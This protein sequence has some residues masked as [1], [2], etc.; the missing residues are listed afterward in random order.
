MK[1]FFSHPFILS[2]LIIVGL[3]FL[4]SQGWLN[5]IKDIFYSSTKPAQ[6][7]FYQF[8]HQINKLVVFISSIN[9]LEQENIELRKENQELLARVAQLQEMERE[10]QFLHQQIGLSDSEPKELILARVIGQEAS[11]LGRYFLINKGKKDGVKEKAIV[12]TAGNLLV[13]RVTEVASSFSKVQLIID[14]NSR[15]NALI[16]ESGMTGLVKGDQGLSLVIDLLPQGEVIEKGQTVVSSGRAGLF[17]AGLLIGQIQR[18]ISSDVQISQ[19][20]KVKP[21]VDFNEL[22]RVFVIKE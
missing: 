3:I 4:N 17:P 14:A 22:E 12:I 6:E 16:Q 18:V 11:G 7:I 5:P 2:W 10:N 8:S 21:A 15:V 1:K 9:Q 20:A 19:I 13:G